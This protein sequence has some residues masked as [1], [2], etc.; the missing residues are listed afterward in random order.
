[1]NK[2]RHE[3][4]A[5]KFAEWQR[6]TEP[7]E[8][9]RLWFDWWCDEDDHQALI[10]ALGGKPTAVPS[11]TPYEA[12]PAPPLNVPARQGFRSAPLWLLSD[13]DDIRAALTRHDDF[14]NAPYA[15]LGGGS[16]LLAQDPLPQG[17]QGPD[18]HAE[19]RQL[20]GSLL[21]AFTGGAAPQPASSP[22]RE[23][24]K[25]SVQ[26]AALTALVRDEFDVAV[27]AEQAVLRYLGQLYGFAV[28]DHGL[29]EDASRSVYH[30]LQYVTVGQHFVTEPA[31]LPQA[32][33][34]LAR[35]AARCSELMES[36][37]WLR[38]SPRRYGP[39]NRRAWPD[40][41]TPWSTQPFNGL[42]P[43]LLAR[44]ARLPGPLSGRD[45]AS[46]AAAL[47]A[48][49]GGNLVSAACLVVDKLMDDTAAMKVVQA[50]APDAELSAILGPMLAVRPPLPAV[51]RRTKRDGVILSDGT[52]LNADTDC[53]VLLE[54]L[55][56]QSCPHAWGEVAAGG[57]AHACL[58]Q[59]LITPL[60]EQLVHRV[61]R[62]PLLRRALDPLTGQPLPLKRRWGFGCTSL[63][64]F[65]ERNQR[66]AGGR[67]RRHNLIVVMRVKSPVGEHAAALRRLI[68]GA[69]PRIDQVLRDF[70]HVEHAW[71]ELSDGDGQLVLR[72]LYEGD[73][74]SY[75]KHFAVFA[76]DLFDRLFAHIEDAPPMPVAEFPDEFV[77]TI[78]RF[79][80]APLG[81]FLY[82]A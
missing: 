2:F 3:R 12:D 26:Q 1:M 15:D 66:E 22:L 53:L 35:L 21:A 30:A 8:Q 75:I 52:K 37:E 11:R 55:A 69:V 13:P 7:E 81:G 48:G 71:F 23:L 82:G 57:A 9:N 60:L 14:S 56:K 17:A 68:I 76:G 50:L 41:V 16:F 33:Q 73:F 10:A 40:G 47:L 79:N 6:L 49:T 43:P 20:I 36:Y 34:Q 59:A 67:A 44:L 27:L 54:G 42:H 45:R 19:Q 24:A 63:P 62:L 70:K 18:W 61:A 38:R 64:L 78:R 31:L 77:E 28:H 29:L 51:P 58:G 25:V 39:S 65:H 74:D 72:T 4:P 80:R 32:R 46:L 5:F